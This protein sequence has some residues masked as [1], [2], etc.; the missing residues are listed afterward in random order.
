MLDAEDADPLLPVADELDPLLTEVVKLEEPSLCLVP[1]GDELDCID[2]TVV[3]GASPLEVEETAASVCANL[4]TD[5]IDVGALV[6]LSDEADAVA[7]AT[8][9]EVPALALD[10]SLLTN[11]ILSKLPVLSVHL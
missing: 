6:L 10:P 1:V 8:E 11:S 4:L 3:E 7:D 2:A 5:T 9:D